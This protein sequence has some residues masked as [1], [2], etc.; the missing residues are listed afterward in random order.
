MSPVISRRALVVAVVLSF[1]LPLGIPHDASGFQNGRATPAQLSPIFTP[2]VGKVAKLEKGKVAASWN[3]LNLCAAA[4]GRPLSPGDS[5]SNPVATAYRP[6]NIQ[7]DFKRIFGVNAATPGRS[8]HG[9]GRAVDTRN[10]KGQRAYINSRGPPFGWSKRTSDAPWEEWH[11]SAYMPTVSKFRRP[12]PGASFRYPRIMRGSGG[13]CQAPAVKEWQRRLRELGHYSGAIDG[14]YGKATSKG[15]R[16]LQKSKGFRKYLKK[17]KLK[18]SPLGVVQS[19]EWIAGRKV[20]RQVKDKNGGGSTVRPNTQ[21]QDVRATQGLLVARLRELNRPKSICKIDGRWDTCDKRA[22][23]KFQHLVGLKATGVAD[24]RTYA[25]LRKPRERNAKSLDQRGL[26]FLAREEGSRS[27]PYNDSVGHCTGGIGH[28]IHFGRCDGRASERAW[29]N[30]SPKTI[31]AR[32]NK[33]LERYV[34][35]VVRNVRRP[36]KQNQLNASASLTFNIGIGGWLKSTVLRQWNAGN[37]RAAADAF[38]LWDNPPVLRG[39]RLRERTLYL[40][41]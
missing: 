15:T 35:A 26:L 9:L 36:I 8:N 7:V 19:A 13:R 32:F 25:A 38:L 41:P 2:Q 12:D 6:Y 16:R 37:I 10:D 29:R 11:Y 1:V 27:N 20:T 22:L 31:L 14:E 3:T 4:A 33:D 17:H 24:P 21:G 18:R 40:T 34:A 39:R 28:L 5:A 30:L 23:K